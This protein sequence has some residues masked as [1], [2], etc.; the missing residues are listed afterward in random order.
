MA[1][2]TSLNRCDKCKDGWY[3]KGGGECSPC[4]C[5]NQGTEWCGKGGECYCREGF[6]GRTCDRCRV[7]GSSFPA[8][9]CQG[10]KAGDMCETCSPGYYKVNTTN[11]LSFL[12]PAYTNSYHS[13]S[14][15]HFPTLHP[16]SPQDGGSGGCI[17]CSCSQYSTCNVTT[18]TCTCNTGFTGPHCDTCQDE[19]LVYPRCEECTCNS[20]GSLTGCTNCTC[21]VVLENG[22]TWV[23]GAS[24]DL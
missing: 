2:N 7:A 19:G 23:L 5:N 10:N 22:P 14:P 16:N 21:K 12:V 4:Q 1:S 18:G 17:E 15:S 8:C 13:F 11:Y 3:R 9:G 20:I 6:T 24:Y